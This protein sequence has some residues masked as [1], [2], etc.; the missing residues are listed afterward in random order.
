[1]KALRKV[2]LVAAVVVLSSA[3]AKA[4]E[5]VIDAGV[6][7]VSGAIVAGPVGF[8]GGGVLGYVAGPEITCGL[9]INRCYRHRH[10]HRHRR[11]RHYGH[12][13]GGGYGADDV[14]RRPDHG[15]Y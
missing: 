1:M 10:R 8:V 4:G 14:G 12:R 9:G 13:G 15:N 7:A 11:H 3:A 2:A 6:G 5:R